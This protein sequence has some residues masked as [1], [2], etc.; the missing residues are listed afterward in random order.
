MLV[1][2]MSFS[3]SVRLVEDDSGNLSVQP[4]KRGTT[5]PIEYLQIANGRIVGAVPENV[6]AALRGSRA[7]LVQYATSGDV[8]GDRD[9][10]VGYAG[11]VIQ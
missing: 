5:Q 4:G 3:R 7:E 6:A 1:G 9:R 8:S 11:I 10:V 2:R